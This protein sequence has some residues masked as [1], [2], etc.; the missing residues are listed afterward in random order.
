MYVCQQIFAD[1]T[2]K[3]FRTNDAGE[4][5]NDT[6]LPLASNTRRMLTQVDPKDE[7]LVYA[8]FVDGGAGNKVYRSTNGGDFW[9]NIST[10][11]LDDEEE[12]RWIS[13]VYGTNGGLYF[14]ASQT[15]FYKNNSMPDWEG[16][17]DG[18]PIY[19]HVHKAV[20]F[21][22]DSKIRIASYGKGIWE[23][24]LRDTDFD[25]IAQIAVDELS[26]TAVCISD[27]ITFKYLDLYVLDH[28]GACCNW[29]FEGGTPATSTNIEE[30]VNYDSP[31]TY[32]TILTI[33]DVTGN[34]DVDSI[35]VDVSAPNLPTII[36]EDFETGVLPPADFTVTN[37]D[38]SFTWKQ[39]SRRLWLK[40]ERHCFEML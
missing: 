15:I 19:T 24:G 28:E 12:T 25:P 31:G 35:Y 17:R 6:D 33:A 1:N 3:V 34:R 7:N 37:P 13:L 4:T 5:W 30:Q 23:S 10:A 38:F 29:I 21:Y 20:P 27:E 8:A 32:L 16:F 36:D 18:L 22:R 11:T 14:G 40:Y 39:S 26:K 2:R 9:E